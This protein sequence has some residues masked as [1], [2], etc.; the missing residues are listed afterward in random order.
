MPSEECFEFEDCTICFGQ[1]DI[2]C[3][4]PCSGCGG[5]GYNRFIKNPF[6]GKPSPI[7]AIC[8]SLATGKMFRVDFADFAVS[9]IRPF[10]PES[11]FSNLTSMRDGLTLSR[12][13]F[14]FWGLPRKKQSLEFL[15]CD[16]MLILFRPRVDGISNSMDFQS[17]L[18]CRPLKWNASEGINYR[19]RASGFAI[20]YM[21]TLEMY[22]C[23]TDE[24][25]QPVSERFA[26]WLPGRL[27]EI[28]IAL[29]SLAENCTAEKKENEELI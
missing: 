19:V 1:G 3:G 15:S 6:F 16:E 20:V 13:C 22:F 11:N 28:K 21:D 10:L 25:G 24:F 12:A 9:M 2:D 17:L 5:E 4:I 14:V 18:I 29:V 27:D 8:I 23:M 7:T 26:N